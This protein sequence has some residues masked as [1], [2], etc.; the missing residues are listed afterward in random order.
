MAKGKKKRAAN[1]V[2]N[3][4]FFAYQSAGK[5]GTCDNVDA[6][7]DAVKKIGSSAIIWENMKTNGKLINK[8]ILKHIDNS[9]IF[10]CDMTYLNANV[11]FELD[12]TE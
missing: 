9:M 3:K 10:A 2:G 6:I 7:R 4:I 12:S 5:S 8:E 1:R 11:F